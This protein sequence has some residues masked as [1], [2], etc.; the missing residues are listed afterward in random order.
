MQRVHRIPLDVTCV[1]I[2][3][4]QQSSE[5]WNLRIELIDT[6][7]ERLVAEE[8]FLAGTNEI[9]QHLLGPFTSKLHA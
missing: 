3:S 4:L 1:G 2:R 7:S 8:R 9:A 5:G 6:L